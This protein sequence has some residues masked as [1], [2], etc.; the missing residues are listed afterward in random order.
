MAAIFK[1]IRKTVINKFF[2]DFTKR[3]KDRRVLGLTDFAQNQISDFLS[4]GVSLW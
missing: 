4:F 3:K 1:V 2:I